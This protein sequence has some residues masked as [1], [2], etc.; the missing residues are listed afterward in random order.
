MQLAKLKEFIKDG[1]ILGFSSAGANNYLEDVSIPVDHRTCMSGHIYTFKSISQIGVTL[2]VDEWF[3]K[4]KSEYLDKQPIFISL[5]Q[6][7][8]MEIGLNL[9]VMPT[10]L[11]EELVRSYLKIITPMLDKIVNSDG[12]FISLAERIKL[13]ANY[14]LSRLVNRDFFSKYEYW[15]DKYRREDM[16]YLTLIDWPDV[17]KLTKI[18]YSNNIIRKL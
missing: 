15:I 13:P 12:N 9:K 7:G 4:S 17:P 14:S 16:S 8:P 6:E 18:N 1:Q 10:R 11:T 5:G 3:E 2:S